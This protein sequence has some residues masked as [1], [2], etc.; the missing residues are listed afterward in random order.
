MISHT[1]FQYEQNMIFKFNNDTAKLEWRLDNI[2]KLVNTN[3]LSI[4]Q[5]K[6]AAIMYSKQLDFNDC[7][8]ITE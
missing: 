5:N 7:N 2:F 1:I 8:N 4:N 6:S 3:G